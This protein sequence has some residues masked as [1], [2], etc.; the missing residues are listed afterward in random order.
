MDFDAA[1]S[2]SACGTSLDKTNPEADKAL[3]SRN[4]R[5]DNGMDLPFFC[6]CF[7]RLMKKNLNTFQFDGA[8]GAK[9]SYQ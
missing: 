9:D 4:P 8:L 2:A 1:S 6:F 5:R 3:A 7:R